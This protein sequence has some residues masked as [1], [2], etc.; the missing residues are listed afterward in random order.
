MLSI[1]L[2]KTLLNDESLDA[3][4]NAGDVGVEPPPVSAHRNIVQKYDA[5][6][7]TTRNL[8]L[9]FDFVLPTPTL[10]V[11]DRL[12]GRK[13]MGHICPIMD[14]MPWKHTTLLKAP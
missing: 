5:H 9:A 6:L 4:I 7:S 14:N 3:L 2:V 8:S 10:L 12:R 13:L 11:R 1:N